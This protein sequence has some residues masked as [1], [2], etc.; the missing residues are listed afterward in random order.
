ML[1][2]TAAMYACRTYCCE[3]ADT[4]GSTV[5]LQ[6]APCC[7]HG[8]LAFEKLSIGMARMRYPVSEHPAVSAEQ[9]TGEAVVAAGRTLSRLAG[10]AGASM[11]QAAEGQQWGPQNPRAQANHWLG[12]HTLCHMVWL[13]CTLMVSNMY[14]TA[15]CRLQL[16][17]CCHNPSCR[18][19]HCALTVHSG[20]RT[21]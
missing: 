18:I 12:K 15:V 11:H 4:S 20:L 2:A 16:L 5:L 19:R 10:C 7:S 17:A 13:S 3:V 21:P 6:Q 8:A 1:Q 9:I 14:F